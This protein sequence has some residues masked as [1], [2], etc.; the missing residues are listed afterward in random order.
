MTKVEDKILAQYVKF[1]HNMLQK[2]LKGLVDPIKL[3]NVQLPLI[4]QKYNPY[5]R[6]ISESEYKNVSIPACKG[7][8]K[9]DIYN[10]EETGIVFTKLARVSNFKKYG[11]NL[12]QPAT[13][14][15]DVDVYEM[16]NK[17]ADFKTLFGSLGSDLKSL[18][19]ESQE[20]IVKFVEKNNRWLCADNKE[21]FF[22]FSEEIDGEE[23][24][25]VASAY[26]QFGVNTNTYFLHF[27]TKWHAKNKYRIVVPATKTLESQS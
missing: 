16:Y 20:Q 6:L 25:F 19:F 22:L 15:I 11:I 8:E 4:G 18:V 7:G 27:D 5:L 24:L 13:E 10:A 3:M 14:K 2:V 12:P 26:R 1:Q 21:T 23:E 17:D 9:A